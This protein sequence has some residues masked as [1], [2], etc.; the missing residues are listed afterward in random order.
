MTSDLQMTSDGNSGSQFF[1][2]VRLDVRLGYLPS[3]QARERER[4]IERERERKRDDKKC[5]FDLQICGRYQVFSNRTV[6]Q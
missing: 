5:V 2:A 1:S 6:L 3:V 4:E